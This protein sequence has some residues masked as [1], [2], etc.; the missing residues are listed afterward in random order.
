VIL[1]GSL[2][3][4]NKTDVLYK[5]RPI[6][7][8]MKDKYKDVSRCGNEIAAEVCSVSKH[9]HSCSNKS[10]LW[11]IIPLLGNGPGITREEW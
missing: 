8:L 5:M 3:K 9:I 7:E 11:H 6:I 4:E 1:L 10:M 2:I